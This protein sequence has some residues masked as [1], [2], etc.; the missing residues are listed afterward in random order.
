[1]DE[2]TKLLNDLE[3]LTEEKFIVAFKD[4]FK[5]F[6]KESFLFHNDNKFISQV[7][8]KLI[9]NIFNNEFKTHWEN[10][11]V[12]KNIK[13]FMAN[14]I[15]FKTSL[16]AITMPHIFWNLF[17]I[18][19]NMETGTIKSNEQMNELIKKSSTESMQ[20]CFATFDYQL[21]LTSNNIE[22]LKRKATQGEKFLGKSF[23]NSEIEEF[24][25]ILQK[26]KESEKVNDKRS[27]RSITFN[28]AKAFGLD[29]ESEQQKFYKRFLNYKNKKQK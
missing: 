2:Q 20:N 18:C 15:S 11:G 27:L 10:L 25:K 12:P 19:R 21:S 7:D 14:K 1:M 4:N 29:Q 6:L 17:I 3:K 16:A 5:H 13:L 8:W 26:H 22:E 9:Y 23:I 24:E 28:V